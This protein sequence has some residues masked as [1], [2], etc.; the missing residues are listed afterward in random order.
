MRWD[1][2]LLDITPVFPDLGLIIIIIIIINNLKNKYPQ[3][4][5]ILPHPPKYYIT[6]F[7]TKNNFLKYQ[8]T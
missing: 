7:H 8:H 5:Q 4:P 6:R 3:T 1:Y 2:P